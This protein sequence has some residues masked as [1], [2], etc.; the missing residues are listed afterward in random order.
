MTPELIQGSPE[1][2]A[3]RKTKITATDASVIMRVN[4]WKT[5]SKLY[6]EKTS[7]AKIVINDRMQ[8]GTD[9]EPMARSLFSIQTGIDVEPR[10]VIKD[11]A[12]ASLD[13]ISACGNH[14]V[15]IKC[16]GEKDHALALQNKIPDHYY[17]QLQHQM[18]I[19]DVSK[20]I[21]FSFDGIDGVSV[22]VERDDDYI[23]KMVE[24]EKEFYFCLLNRTPPKIKKKG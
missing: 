19:C 13:G 11:W 2:I 18:W 20:M 8:R 4:P 3:L 15:E 24:A 17:P 9:L 14:L 5:P 21:Y 1:W 16:P 10:V 7:D 23:K 22:I 12:M 6:K